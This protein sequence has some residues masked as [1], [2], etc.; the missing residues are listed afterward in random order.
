MTFDYNAI[1][2]PEVGTREL[3]EKSLI[4]ALRTLV[5]KDTSFFWI[6]YIPS[7]SCI[8]VSL[9]LIIFNVNLSS[10]FIKKK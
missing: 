6:L 5:V 7:I 9:S 1:I 10:F 3:V 4:S 8:F 2:P